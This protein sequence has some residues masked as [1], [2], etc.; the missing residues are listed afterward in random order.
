VLGLWC[1]GLLCMDSHAVHLWTAKNKNRN[2]FLTLAAMASLPMSSLDEVSH[3]PFQNDQ[4][5]VGVRPDPPPW[6][7][8]CLN[9]PWASEG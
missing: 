6:A 3:I 9:L 1:T 2:Q 5:T 4:K 7:S 8:A